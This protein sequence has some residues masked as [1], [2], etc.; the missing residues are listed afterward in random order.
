M[1]LSWCFL[2]LLVLFA[3]VVFQD[4]AIRIHL[5]AS[6]LAVLLN[7]GFIVRALL[8]PANDFPAVS[9]CL[10]G[11]LHFGRNVGAADA[12]HFVFLST[13]LR[14]NAEGK[15]SAHRDHRN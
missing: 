9:L 3:L 5:H 12:V 1:L 14:A 2:A 11:F 4:F 8:F 7:N 15:A 13:C 6:L 10:S